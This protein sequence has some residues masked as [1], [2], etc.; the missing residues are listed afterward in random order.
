MLFRSSSKHTVNY[1]KKKGFDNF[2]NHYFIPHQTSDRALS[3]IMRVLNKIMKDEVIRDNNLIKNVETR[4]NT[5][6]T[7]HIVALWDSIINGKINSHDKIIFL[8]QASGMNI[9]LA[10]YNLDKLPERIQTNVEIENN[11]KSKRR[12]KWA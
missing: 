7:A 3:N 5:S 2:R 8:I 1:L 6:S 10:D 9:G 4:G 11:L 12:I